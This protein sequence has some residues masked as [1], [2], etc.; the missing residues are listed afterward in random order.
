VRVLSVGFSFSS[1]PQHIVLLLVYDRFNFSAFDLALVDDG[2]AAVAPGAE[3]AD[4]GPRARPHRHRALPA[5]GL[6]NP[7]GVAACYWVGIISGSP[8]FIYAGSILLGLTNG[9]GQL[10]GPW[11]RATSLRSRRM[12][13]FTTAS[14]LS[15]MAPMA[16]VAAPRA[17][18]PVVLTAIG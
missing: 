12:Y 2:G 15:T 4:L 18:V 3:F 13:P 7:V 11:R 10:P 5:A 6:G 17:V 8:F 1:C 14:T 16:S 9:G